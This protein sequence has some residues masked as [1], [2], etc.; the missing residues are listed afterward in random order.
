MSLPWAASTP[1]HGTGAQSASD[2]PVLR[3]GAVALAAALPGLARAGGSC[4]VGLL[5]LQGRACPSCGSPLSRLPTEHV[6]SRHLLG[7]AAPAPAGVGE[8]PWLGQPPGASPGP[9]TTLTRS[10][11]GAGLF[12]ETPSGKCLVGVLGD[13]A[14]SA[15]AVPAAGLESCPGAAGPGVAPRIPPPAPGADRGAQA[16][17]WPAALPSAAGPLTWLPGRR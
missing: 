15:S 5:R 13:A 8:A 3:A 17:A 12:L 6:T 10:S 16:C 1:A 4:E 7:P 2:Q 9:R 14:G 11:P